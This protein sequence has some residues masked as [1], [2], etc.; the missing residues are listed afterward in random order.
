MNFRIPAAPNEILSGREF[1]IG[2]KKSR[3]PLLQTNEISK[4]S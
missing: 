2:A 1:E 4:I 3:R